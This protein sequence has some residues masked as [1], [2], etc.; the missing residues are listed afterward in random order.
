MLLGNI[1]TTWNQYIDSTGVKFLH[2]TKKKKQ[3]KYQS[4]MI[5]MQYYHTVICPI[6]PYEACKSCIEI[7]R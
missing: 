5:Q 1:I 6:G 7:A 4:K 3:D 2:E